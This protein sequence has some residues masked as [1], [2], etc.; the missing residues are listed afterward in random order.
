[1]SVK[2]TYVA[3]SGAS[4]TLELEPGVSVMQAGLD[5]AVPEIQSDCGGV[6]S[7]ASC[8]VYVD[9]DWLEKIPPMSKVENSLLGLLGVRKPN[10]R[11]SCQIKAAAELDGLV[12][13]TLDPDANE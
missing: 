7:C 11:L 9:P 5:A 4:R 12:V 8:H 10:S 1:M 3:S 13:R 6:C 2:V